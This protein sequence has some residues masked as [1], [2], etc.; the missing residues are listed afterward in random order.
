MMQDMMNDM[1]GHMWGI[2][3]ITLL[4]VLV[5]ALGVA[6]LVK[7]LFF[8]WPRRLPRGDKASRADRPAP[9]QGGQP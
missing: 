8:K 2:G 4:V 3:L 5:L 6:A 7:Y 9:S 1:M